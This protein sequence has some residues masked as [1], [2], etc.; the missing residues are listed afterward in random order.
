MYSVCGERCGNRNANEPVCEGGSLSI[1][2]QQPAA[3]FASVGKASSVIKVELVEAANVKSNATIKIA[4]IAFSSSEFNYS[5][6]INPHPICV[7]C[8]GVLWHL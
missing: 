4:L 7:S 5:L 2:C 6:L 8:I 1:L 3:K